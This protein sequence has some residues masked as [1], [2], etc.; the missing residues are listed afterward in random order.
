MVQPRAEGRGR[1]GP[2][3]CGQLNRAVGAVHLYA[4]MYGMKEQKL[5]IRISQN[6]LDGAKR[7]AREHGTSLTRLVTSYLERLGTSDDA[8][9]SAPIT[10][11]LTSSLPSDARR[12][13]YREHLEHK[14]G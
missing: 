5:T 11:S 7:H 9:A 1:S 3:C 13:E 10:R 6:V 8:L 2:V 4:I 12:S 14:H